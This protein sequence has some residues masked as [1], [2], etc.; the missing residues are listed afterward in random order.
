M[1]KSQIVA[2]RDCGLSYHSIAARVG[3]DPTTVSR[4]WNRWV[5]DGNTECC[6]GSQR[7]FITNSREDRHV[8]LMALMV[9]RPESRMGDVCTNSST[10][11]A[12]AW[13]FSSETAASVL[14]TASRGHI[15]VWWYRDER[16]LAAS[17]RHRHTGSSPGVMVWSGIRYTS[18]S[19]LV[20]PV[21]T[22]NSTRYTSGVLSPVFLPFIQALRNPTFQ[23]DNTRPEVAYIV[24]TFLETKN[25]RLFPWPARSLDLSPIENV[26]SMVAQRVARHHT[27]VTTVNEL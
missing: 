21:S 27:L 25:V 9:T 7:P 3:R 10:T 18:R 14:F 2:Y 19:P 4:I 22:L 11:F 23:Q 13:T 1:D 15:R 26:R 24:R 5:Q 16:T 17:I 20:H 6:S 12:A 8:T